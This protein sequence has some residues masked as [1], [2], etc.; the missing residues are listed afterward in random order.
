M[1]HKD[2]TKLKVLASQLEGEICKELRPVKK[3]YQ[4]MI[5]AGGS[6]VEARINRYPVP[7][8][9]TALIIIDIIL[10][11][12]GQI[13]N[14]N[15][16]FSLQYKDDLDEDWKDWDDCQGHTICEYEINENFIMI[17]PG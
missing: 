1:D 6:G 8:P 3:Y 4:L 16:M 5:F 15:C 14:D 12:F 13:G 2:D 17:L 9:K 7:D 11:E 10:S